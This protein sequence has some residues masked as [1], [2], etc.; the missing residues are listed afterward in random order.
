VR[1]TTSLHI[2]SDAGYNRFDCAL[3]KRAKLSYIDSILIRPLMKTGENV[4]FDEGN[5]PCLV[6]LHVKKKSSMQ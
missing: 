4:L 1:L 5:I 3:Y 2:P 6:I